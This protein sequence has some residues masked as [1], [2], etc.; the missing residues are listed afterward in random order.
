MMV[1][2]EKDKGDSL[3]E[4]D[5]VYIPH[6]MKIEKVIEETQNIKTFHFNFKDETQ[7]AQFGFKSGQFAEYSVFGVGE[8][9]FCISS[10][11]TRMDHLEFSVM[12]VGNVTQ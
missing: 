6:V 5:N 12:R 10:S 3:M 7:K 11:P 4:G 2:V 9:T 8:A 1:A